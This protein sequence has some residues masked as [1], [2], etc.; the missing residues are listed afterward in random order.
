M[1]LRISLRC[2]DEANML[3]YRL[4]NKMIPFVMI[5]HQNFKILDFDS[6]CESELFHIGK[7]ISRRRLGGLSLGLQLPLL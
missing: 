1:E 4:T 3:M 7:M 5:K 2:F 6:S